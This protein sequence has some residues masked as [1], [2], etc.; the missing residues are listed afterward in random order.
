MYFLFTTILFVGLTSA[1]CN[2]QPDKDD[3]FDNIVDDF[4]GS[5]WVNYDGRWTYTLSFPQKNALIYTEKA[6]NGTSGSLTGTYTKS[7][8]T[9]NMKL[10]G[11]EVVGTINGGTMSTDAFRNVFIKQ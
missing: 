4:V 2:K 11:G 5:S 6:P 1:S 8:N 7:G 9:V 10:L 3:V